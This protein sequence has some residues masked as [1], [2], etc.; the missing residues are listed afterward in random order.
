MALVAW[1]GGT[2]SDTAEAAIFALAG[3][4]M[5]PADH[6]ARMNALL[7]AGATAQASR[8]IA[9]VTP[10]ARTGFMARLSLLQGS[11]PGTLGLPVPGD[12][13]RDPGYVYAS[14]RQARARGN[15]PG[16][17]QLLSLIHI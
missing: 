17:I 13:L 2:M 7:W 1:R 11:A 16:A 12:A 6:D 15:L 14:V 8:Q 4:S 3:S 5:T 9:Y 10:Y